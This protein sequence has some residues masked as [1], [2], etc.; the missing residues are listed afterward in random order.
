MKIEV[1]N[2]PPEFVTTLTPSITVHVG[3]TI[4]YSLPAFADTDVTMVFLKFPSGLP[5]HGTYD[6]TTRIIKFAPDY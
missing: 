5:H 4:D 2:E 1:Q 6:S 3:A